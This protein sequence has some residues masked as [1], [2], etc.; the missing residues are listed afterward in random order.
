VSIVTVP[1]N[2]YGNI[3]FVKIPEIGSL[4][5]CIPILNETHTEVKIYYDYKVVHYII[6]TNNKKNIEITIKFRKKK[7]KKHKRCLKINIFL[8]K[9]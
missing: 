8:K 7:H 4:M 1:E 5:N 6:G 3:D 9:S 2:L